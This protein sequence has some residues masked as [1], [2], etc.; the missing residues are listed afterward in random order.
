MRLPAHRKR[1]YCPL[2][3]EELINDGGSEQTETTVFTFFFCEHKSHYAPYIVLE[4]TALETNE[5]V[6]LVSSS[7]GEVVMQEQESYCFFCGSVLRMSI[8]CTEMRELEKKEATSFCFYACKKNG[9]IW[10]VLD[11]TT[12]MEFLFFSLQNFDTLLQVFGSTSSCHVM[13]PSHHTKRY[14]LRML[15]RDSV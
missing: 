11:E 14:L 10:Q 7:T 1:S 8:M 2:C 6:V 4:C 12:Q 3:G 15:L 13:I 9:H 5:K